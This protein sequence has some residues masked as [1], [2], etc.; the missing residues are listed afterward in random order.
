MRASLGQFTRATA[1]V[2]LTSAVVMVASEKVYWYT[3]GYT[4]AAV[5]ELTLFYSLA[6]MPLLYA[7]GRYSVDTSGRLVLAAGIFA[8]VI[9]GIITPVVYSDG[10]L[11]V[12]FL[13]F[14]GWHG[15]LSVVFMWHAVHRWALLGRRRVL[16]RW[17]GLFGVA[18]G[19][20]STNYWRPE[21]IAEQ[22]AENIESGEAWDVGQWAV[23]KFALFAFGF[24]A[25][26]IGCHWLLGFVWPEE[27]RPSRGWTI[28]VALALAAW[29]GLWTVA[30]PYAPLKFAAV[31]GFLVWL[32]RRSRP[33]P[34]GLTLLA[35]N[36]GRVRLANLLPLL[37][38]PTAAVAGYAL[39]T[40]LDLGDSVLETI[41]WTL[42]AATLSGG[43]LAAGW[44]IF[45]TWRP[46][47]RSAPDRDATT[48]R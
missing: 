35:R 20:W 7:V 39:M 48:V 26:V 44:A 42:V 36:S 38:M 34:G 31:V 22:T 17:S 29:L 21:T 2:I 1:F 6:V 8:M 40:Q 9:E 37:C 11:P 41:Y 25:F 43:T 24:T 46:S 12:M 28:S 18:W 32:L 3:G 45:A 27:W 15:L 30:V 14:L 33:E 23:P 16:A 19:V 5:V 47:S 13:Y 4:P 10:P